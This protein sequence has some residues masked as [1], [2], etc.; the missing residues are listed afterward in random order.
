MSGWIKVLIAWVDA[1]AG[2]DCTDDRLDW[3]RVL[4]FLV[5]H[6]ACFGVLWVGWS[7]P[8]VV[9]CLAMYALRMFAVTAFYHRYFSHRSFQTNRF[10][11]FIF[12]LWGATSVQRGA[13]WWAA[14]HRNH[15]RHSDRP[16]DSHSPLQR[17]FGWAHWGWFLSRR[18]FKTDYAMVKDWARFPELRF[19][20]RFD[21]L[22]PILFALFTFGAGMLARALFGTG[23]GWQF[24]IWGFVIS[25]VMLAHGT[26][27][28][29][30]LAHV[31]GRVRYETG[32]GS[33]NNRLL[34]LITLGEGWHNNH[35]RYPHSVRQG[36]FPGEWDP[37]Y[38]GLRVMLALGMVRKLR[39]VPVS[40]LREGHT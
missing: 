17:G 3:F 38:W 31:W 15:H 2:P 29:N 32:D 40:V 21:V 11:Q 27:T 13:L 35:H 14:H 1:D 22:V 6:L 36:F 25:T 33:R 23:S 37:T 30:S 8:A 34:A 20:N 12:A 26:F 10:W 4:P 39:G 9:F 7:W 28:I 18:H 24:F 5:L 16:E 19:I